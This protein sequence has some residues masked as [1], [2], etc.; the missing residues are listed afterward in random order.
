MGS[1]LVSKL[2]Q[3]NY[4]VYSLE[5][6]VTG[7]YVMGQK[8]N[9]KT[10]FGDLRENFSVERILHEIQPDAVIHLASI[11]PV[12]YSYDHPIEVIEANFLATVNLAEACLREVPHFKHFLFA[13]TSETYGNGPNPKR[14]DTPQNPNSPYAVSKH[15]CEKYL[16]YM[17]D[18]YGFPVTILRNFN[19]Y[20]RTENTHFVVERAIVQMLKGNT[21]RLGDPAPIRDLQYVEDHVNSYLTCL[22]NPRA[23]GE[24]FNFCTGKGTSVKQLADLIA[25]LTDFSGEVIW[26]TIPARPLDI[27]ELIGDNTK[28]QKLL[29][30]RPKFDLIDGLKLTLD[31][32]RRKLGDSGL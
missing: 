24:I 10:V 27:M 16:L 20:G 18:A 8:R 31:Y 21:V 1:N 32:W 28:A 3:Y 23:K 9:I 4:D 22:E 29:G 19:T 30:W 17:R 15:A 6:Y 7:R 11:S 13:S 5:R 2:D 25:K 12:S 26:S 14:E